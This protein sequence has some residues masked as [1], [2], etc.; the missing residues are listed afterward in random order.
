MDRKC[1]RC[2]EVKP[3]TDFHK[4]AK[5]KFGRRYYCK[6]C[7]NKEQK[8]RTDSGYYKGKYKPKYNKSYSRNQKLKYKYGITEEKYNSL[9]ETCKGR[10][11]ICDVWC[12]V[13][14]VDHNHET[15]EVRGLLCNKCN[16]GLG[17][18]KDNSDIIEKAKRYLTNKKGY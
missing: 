4:A 11:N 15:G 14:S 18:F 6:V 17:M 1:C 7:A 13:L 3:L 9:Y 2:Q 10:C 16:I 8:L 5:K 12:K